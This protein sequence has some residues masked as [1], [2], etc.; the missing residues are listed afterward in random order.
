MN[1]LVSIL[2]AIL[3]FGII[4]LVHELGHFIAA[5]KCGVRVNE[6]AIGMGPAIFKK[7]RGETTYA[8]RALPIGGY[9]SM[10][11]ED[12]SSDD[13]RAFTKKKV[14]QRLVITLAGATMNIILGLVAMIIVTCMSDGISS[15]IISLFEASSLPQQTGLM[16]NDEIVAVNGVRTFV[17]SDIVYQFQI[18]KENSFEM[19]VIRDGKK[20]ELS[21]VKLSTYAQDDGKEAIYVDFL[22]KS[23]KKNPL[24]VLEYSAKKTV[25]VARL[26]WLTLIDMITGNV[27]MNDLSGPVGIVDTIGSVISSGEGI[28]LAD[29]IRQ[30]LMLVVF[31]SINVG[32]FNLLPFPALDGARAV[33]LIIEGIRRK[34]IKKEFEGL[35]HF[36]GLAIL[37]F[38]ML[39]VTFNDISRIF[40]K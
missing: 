28:Q 27:R 40:N 30:L 14:W 6:F 12:E 37:M 9:C 35:I 10:E 31:I 16:V 2:A 11:G 13:E 18:A 29:T 32:I 20:V 21:G 34:P 7:T 1:S 3:I 39:F 33:F 38:L 4:I 23:I 19:T 22:V 26:I 17:D 8:L 36:V 24:T 15:N 25:S 5:K